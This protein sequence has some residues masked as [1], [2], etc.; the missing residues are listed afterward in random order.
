MGASVPKRIRYDSSY[1]KFI[2]SQSW[3]ND[4]DY[5]SEFFIDYK[6]QSQ[7]NKIGTVYFYLII[8]L[9][10]YSIWFKT[11]KC[12]QDNTMIGTKLIFILWTSLL[13]PCGNRFIFHETLQRKTFRVYKSIKLCWYRSFFSRTCNINIYKMILQADR[14]SRTC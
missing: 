6:E 11:L 12:I 1:S 10:L 7:V 14:V 4:F 2:N 3:N 5:S 13:I 8:A 9:P